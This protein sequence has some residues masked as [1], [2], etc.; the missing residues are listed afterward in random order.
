MLYTTY[1]LAHRYLNKI[2]DGYE[3]G[4]IKPV[5]PITVFE[6][7]DIQ[8]AFRYMQKGQHMGKI[9]VRY[10]ENPNDLPTA[11]VSEKIAFDPSVSYFLPG[12]LG[13]LGQAIAIWMADHGA[14]NLVFLSRSGGNNVRHSF[15]EELEAMGCS[16][17]CF[18]GD[19]A[20]IDDVRNAV[21]N[22]KT[23]I[24]GVMQMAMVLRVSLSE[25]KITWL[26]SSQVIIIKY[27]V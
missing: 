3:K 6:A 12:G 5:E 10:P 14:R 1:V 27:V 24:A 18:A 23:R 17:Q 11:T 25:S 26:S 4:T 19:V 8:E 20:N 22:A 13:G 15:F 2:I 21:S 16:A 7:K 9:V